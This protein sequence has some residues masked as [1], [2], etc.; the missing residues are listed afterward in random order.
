MAKFGKK[1]IVKVDPTDYNVGIIGISGVGKT[2]LMKEA[3]EKMLGEDGYLIANIG[4][5]DG[6]DALPNA[7]YEDFPDFETLEEFVED[8]IENKQ[9]DYPNLKVVVFDTMDELFR[10]TEPY[11]VK[12][13][14][15]QNPD[16]TVKTLKAS[17]GGFGSGENKMIEVILDV[18]WR[19]K[20]EAGVSLWFTGH[21]KRKTVT[22][23]VTGEEYETLT[24]NMMEKYFN[25]IK[26]KLH[27]LGVA[28]IDRDIEKIKVKQKIGDAKIVGKVKG[29]SRIITF[30]DDNFNIDSKSRFAEI[31]D[32][33]PLDADE[34]IK[35]IEDAI[36]ASFGNQKGNKK[37]IEDVKVEQVKEKEKKVEE[38][39][40]IKQDDNFI[41]ED[42]NE[43]LYAKFVEY[44]KSEDN[45][46][47]T[48]NAIIDL[49]TETGFKA[50]QFD[51]IPTSVYK[52][53]VALFE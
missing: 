34:F 1:N 32:R 45:D 10:I 19:L 2:T 46:E 13:H 14:N 4:L 18:L 28:S 23:I 31:T 26:T 6:V 22:D 42:M 24:S 38:I 21:T 5:E 40:E 50:S 48:I 41:D 44:Y 37:T 27:I 25:A 49:F 3:L 36:K 9:T 15:K 47:Q 52:K 7:S 43:K 17:F 39:K 53:A 8:V 35:A 30:R 11:I 16:K 20:R 51:K 12:L 33:I 29:E